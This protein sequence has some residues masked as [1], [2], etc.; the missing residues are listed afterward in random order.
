MY[1]MWSCWGWSQ[2]NVL[3]VKFSF[4]GK[5]GWPIVEEGLY[6]R[7]WLDHLKVQ[8]V[9]FFVG[10]RDGNIVASSRRRQAVN[11]MRICVGLQEGEGKGRGGW[12]CVYTQHMYWWNNSHT[13]AH[14]YQEFDVSL[15]WRRRT[16]TTRALDLDNFQCIVMKELGRVERHGQIPRVVW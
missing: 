14:H 1:L 10:V 15:V 2:Q 5:V 16:L 3:K 6:H 13:C 11:G 4:G 12:G 7:S 9:V 8:P